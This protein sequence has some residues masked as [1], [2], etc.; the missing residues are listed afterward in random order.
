MAYQ[1]DLNLSTLDVG[2][3]HD[4]GSLLVASFRSLRKAPRGAFWLVR[5]LL[6][7]NSAIPLLPLLISHV[8]FFD[9]SCPVPRLGVSFHP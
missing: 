8:F 6:A 7:I 5:I 3:C 4:P 9:L 1:G 2:M